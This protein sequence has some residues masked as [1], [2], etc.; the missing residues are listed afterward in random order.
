MFDLETTDKF[1]RECDIIEIGALRVREGK[2]VDSFKSLVK[3]KYRVFYLFRGQAT[4]L[5]KKQN[6]IISY[7]LRREQ[8]HY[9]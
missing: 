6:D 1:I 4:V 8:T 9:N 7:F 5:K 3:T 2:I